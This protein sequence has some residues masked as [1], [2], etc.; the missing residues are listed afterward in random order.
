MGHDD[1]SEYGPIMDDK[2]C[3][4]YGY[5]WCPVVATTWWL[6]ALRLGFADPK[7]RIDSRE[8]N[9]MSK[10]ERAAWLKSVGMEDVWE[11]KMMGFLMVSGC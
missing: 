3:P 7:Q 8:W 9:A 5:N 6:D 4:T 10:P 11:A 1:S 2:L